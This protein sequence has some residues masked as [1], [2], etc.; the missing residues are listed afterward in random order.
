V[1]GKLVV[2]GLLDRVGLTTDVIS[3]GK[4]SGILSE[5]STFSESER[6]IWKRMMEEVYRQFVT[7]SAAGRKMTPEKLETLAA[8]R[9]WTG[10]QAQQVGLVDQVGTLRD[11]IAEAKQLAGLDP[12][13]KLELLVLPKPKSFFDQLIEGDLGA[14]SPT[15]RLSNLST[16]TVRQLSELDLL[17]QLF[18]ERTLLWM[19]HRF[20]YE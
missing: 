8:G 18:R 14:H 16:Q 6:A 2:K 4:N 3:R 17:Q 19:P 9:I 15:L 5:F 12:Q 20:R 7:K 13:G 10:R 1:G 11:A